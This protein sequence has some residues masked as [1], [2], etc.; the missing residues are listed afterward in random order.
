MV[1]PSR[2]GGVPVFSRPSAKPC[3]SRVADRPRAG[4]SPMRPAGICVSPIWIR[5]RK[6][7]PVVST[8]APQAKAPTVGRHARQRHGRSTMSRSCAS[9]ST[10]VR[11][12]VAG[13]FRL[14]GGA[15]E[16]AVGLRARTAHRRTLAPVQ[17]P[18]LDAAGVGDAAHHAVERIDLAHQ[19]ALAEAADRRVARHRADR[20][21]PMGEQHRARAHPRRRRCGLAA[22][23]AAADDDDVENRCPL[24]L[25]R[26][27]G[28]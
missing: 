11:F 2:R 22:G 21:R 10:T 12:V 27:A 19:M 1:R 3:R 13:E 23:V 14:H 25:I 9:P 4:A 8:A 24:T 20:G 26:M 28:L 16:L 7:V 18:E 15:I 5:P 17:H 6:N